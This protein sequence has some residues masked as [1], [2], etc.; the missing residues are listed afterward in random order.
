MDDGFGLEASV[1]LDETQEVLRKATT[2]LPVRGPDGKL[3]YDE[4]PM[5]ELIEAF[6]IMKREKAK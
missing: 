4:P 5:A 1:T 3:R 2:P 6:G